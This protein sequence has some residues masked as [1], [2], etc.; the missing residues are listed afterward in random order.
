M[1]YASCHNCYK[2]DI[3]LQYMLF[4]IQEVPQASTG[5]MPFELLFGWWLR[6]LLDVSP[7][8]LG[9]KT[10]QEN[11]LVI[12][13]VWDIKEQ[14]DHVGLIFCE[15]LLLTQEEQ[16]QVCNHPV[17]RKCSS[18]SL[19]PCANSWRAGRAPKL[20]QSESVLLITTYSSRVREQKHKYIIF[21]CL[22]IGQSWPLLIWCLLSPF[23]ILW[24]WGIK[25]PSSPQQSSTSSPQLEH[26]YQ[27]VFSLEFSRGCHHI[28]SVLCTMRGKWNT[29]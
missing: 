10:S 25:A 26:Q 8:D 19:M 12:E 16:L 27:D 1:S 2:W 4:T 6:G 24:R 7:G 21:I 28:V 5:F 13:F 17:P 11:Q 15:C 23:Q 9:R 14:I 29:C 20:S 3:L 22:N 18:S